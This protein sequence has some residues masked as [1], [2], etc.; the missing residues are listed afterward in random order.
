MCSR[1]A[2]SSSSASPSRT[3]T[4]RQPEASTPTA[5]S[6]SVLS[7]VTGNTGA[8]R[9][10]GGIY[11]TGLLTLEDSLVSANH[12]EGSGT[13]GVY[14][15]FETQISDSEISG[16]DGEG[17]SSVGGLYMESN[18]DLTD[19]TITGNSASGESSVGGLYTYFNQE[20]DL[21][22]VKILD[23]S[24]FGK[25]AVGGWWNYANVDAHDLVVD[26]NHGD[27]YGTGGIFVECCTGRLELEDAT[28]SH[29]TA[30]GDST[31]GITNGGESSF[32]NVTIGGNTAGT[33]GVG[34]VYNDSD[35]IL[36]NATIAGNSAGGEGSGGFWNSAEAT[37]RNTII[38]GNT[39]RNCNAGIELDSEG[40]NLSEKAGCGFTDALDLTSADPL[41]GPLA[42]NGGFSMTHALMPGS[43][44]ID[45]AV[46][47]PAPDA[48]QRGV[49]RRQG[50][51][52]DS[53]AF[54]VAVAVTV[55]GVWGDILCDHAVGAED[56]VAMISV[57]ALGNAGE[58]AGD[59]CPAPDESILFGDET[60][61]RRW[62]DVN[63]DGAAN[64]LDGLWILRY[65][66]LIPLPRPEG[67]R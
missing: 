61:P 57:A 37:V 41:L 38:S 34:G 49:P 20:S 44:A 24:A 13:G 6:R 26:G 52:C 5:T 46:D 54:E 2:I 23:N 10:A 18:G 8:P 67:A 27:I 28:I 42:D 21:E 22:R 9:G 1:M 53:G 35:L 4:A 50:P 60:V 36:Q 47:C 40:G 29:N 14:A 3:A 33:S 43:P 15:S 19:V 64:A 12:V 45:A 48:D 7:T 25:Y 55:H 62:G 56:A 59:Q 32:E 11:A 16:N 30:P 58:P 31:G 65:L 51:A 39:P 17:T 63:C 66:A